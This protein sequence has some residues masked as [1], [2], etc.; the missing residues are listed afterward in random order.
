MD[1]T[2]AYK[3]IGDVCIVE[4]GGSPR[5]ID[6]YI[7]DSPDGINWIKIGDTTD[8][9]FITNTAQKIKPEGMSKSRYVQPG[10]FLLSNSM[11]FGRPYI[12]KI[13]GCIH[14]GW[15]V[16]RD[17]Q[18][19]F[20]KRFL[21][22][23]LSSPST[24]RKFKE[25]A[26]GGVVNNL[27]SEMVRNVLVPVPSKEEQ[28]VIV[29][30]LEKI[31]RLIS[32]RK[33]QL[34]KLDELIKA[35]F[36]EM[37][38]D[39]VINPKRYPIIP[40]SDLFDVGSSKRVFESEWRAS[41]VPFYRAREIVKLSK[42]GYVNN[43][44][45][46]ENDLYEKYKSKYGVPRAGDMMVTGVG[47]LGVCYIVQPHDR[48]YF[49]DGNT[50]WFRNKGKC[51]VRFIMEQYNMEFVRR[52]IEANANVSTVGTYTI[53]NA[54]NTLVLVPS[55]EEQNTFDYFVS[56]VDKSK[57][58]VQQSLDKLETLKNALMQQYFG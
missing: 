1:K 51:N 6:K 20:D 7:T 36:V 55:I 41:G 9:M 24:Y 46:I 58:G 18:G 25:M 11:S 44:L 26:V 37:F 2:W 19:A 49:K 52:Q 14:D 31:D 13:D 10:D 34:A 33:Q 29:S 56:Q 40:I 42:D 27:N 53:T 57:A 23:Y 5:P 21:Y 12:L 39:P 50:L 35:R 48:F 22:Y 32:L 8:S 30:V 38:G 3:K 54:N 16:L 15:L 17:D 47:T 4:R 28:E 43:E 45:F